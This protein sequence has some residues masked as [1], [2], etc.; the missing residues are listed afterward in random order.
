MKATKNRKLIAIL[1]KKD[2]N[3]VLNKRHGLTSFIKDGKVI[4]SISWSVG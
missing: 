4:G 3:R 2:K 1:N